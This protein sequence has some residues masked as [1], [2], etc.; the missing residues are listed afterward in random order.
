[1][2]LC[3][4]YTE[5]IDPAALV[6]AG[7][8][9]VSRYLSKPGWPKNLTAAEAAELHAAGLGI[10]LNYETSADFMLG[11]LVAGRACATSARGDAASLGAP[12]STKIFYSADFDASAL[13][14]PVLEEFLR[15]AANVDGSAEVG[16]Y[17][18]LRAVNAADHDGFTTWQTAAWSDGTWNPHAVMRQT[19]EQR[20]IGGVIVDINEVFNPAGLGAWMPPATPNQGDDMA[21]FATGEIKSGP[22][23]VTVVCPPPAGSS[24]NWRTAW[25]SLACDFGDAHVRVAIYVHGVGWKI[26]NDVLVPAHADRV[27]PCAGPLPPGVQKICIERLPGSENIPMGYLIEAV[28]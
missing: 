26:W 12:R 24:V 4:D 13:Q 23:A 11:G 15:G 21:V 20:N 2:I 3:A 18:G 5:R 14:I 17:G 1:M 7:I 6:T 10:V 9:Y 28:S 16:E 22:S 27:N 25:F 19:G 8:S